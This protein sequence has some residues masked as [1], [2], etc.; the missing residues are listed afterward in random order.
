MTSERGQIGDARLQRDTTGHAVQEIQV[1]LVADEFEEA[2]VRRHALARHHEHALFAGADGDVRALLDDALFD[3][4]AALNK[5]N[6]KDFGAGDLRHRAH[7]RGHL[8][9]TTTVL[10]GPTSS[11]ERLL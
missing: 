4:F 11:C 2:K 5:T 3:D 6:A 10:A 9:G 7:H 8:T 1:V